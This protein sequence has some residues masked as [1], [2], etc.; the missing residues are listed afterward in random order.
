MNQGYT[1]D[2]FTRFYEYLPIDR[3]REIYIYIV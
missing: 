2:V 3:E 1:K